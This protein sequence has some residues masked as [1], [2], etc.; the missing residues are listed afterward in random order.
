M[1]KSHFT[2]IMKA[3][4]LLRKGSSHYFLNVE[5][6]YSFICKKEKWSLPSRIRDKWGFQRQQI[7]LK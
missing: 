3:E 2:V 7:S 1:V 4:G 5:F 6:F